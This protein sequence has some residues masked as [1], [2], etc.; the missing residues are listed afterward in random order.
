MESHVEKEDGVSILKAKMMKMN[1][2]LWNFM[3]IIGDDKDDCEGDMDASWIP[4]Q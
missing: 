1:L 2:V 3:V 4:A